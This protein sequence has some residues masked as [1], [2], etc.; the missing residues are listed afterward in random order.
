MLRAVTR[1]AAT[2]PRRRHSSYV[3]AAGDVSAAGQLAGLPATIACVTERLQNVADE[4][5][6][7][8]SARYPKGFTA[9]EILTQLINRLEITDVDARAWGQRLLYARARGTADPP[10]PDGLS[11]A[12]VAIIDQLVAVTVDV[13]KAN[14]RRDAT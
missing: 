9:T 1:P 4:I 11:P 12:L 13:W 10:A 3:G 5:L 8:L 14:R 2:P 7:D 6:K